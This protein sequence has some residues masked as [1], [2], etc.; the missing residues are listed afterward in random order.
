VA[1]LLG[2][3]ADDLTGATDLANTLVRQGMRTVQVIG[4]PAAGEPLPEADAIVVALKSRTIAAAEAVAMSRAALERLKAT[5]AR[6][7]FFK[8]CSTFD[9]TDAG[10]IGPVADALLADLGESFTIACPAFPENKRTIFLGHLFVGDVLLS[11]SS[12]RNHP[13]TPMTDANLVRVLGR[14]TTARVGL[15]PFGVV[16]RGPQAIVAAFARLRADG[17]RYA[18]VDAVEDRHLLDIGAACAEMRLI[19][20]G[21]GIALG[22]PENFRRRGLLRTAGGA[23]ALPATGGSDAVIAGSCSAATL[24]QIEHM[25][26]ARP[27]FAV[28]PMALAAGEDIVGRVLGWARE[29]LADGPVLIYASAPPEQVMRTQEKLGRERAGALIERALAEIAAGLV[30][31]GVR[32]LVIAGGETSGAVVQRL[33]VKAL[34][35]GPQIDPGVPW[36]ATVAEPVL[37]LA[38]KSGNFGGP[39]FFTRAFGMLR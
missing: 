19:T 2:C 9:S 35:I 22:L 11:D 36:T 6:Q 5:G 32:R 17:M 10:N 7:Y 38:L 31:A 26:Q 15:V 21:S 8:Y 4:V 12:M 33:G 37:A 23:D 1:V 29:R 24:A 28:D 3:I 14:Q 30:A 39:D 16:S 27:G 13:L 18:I 34:R 25:R 20:G